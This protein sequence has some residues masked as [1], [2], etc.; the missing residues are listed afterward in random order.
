MVSA[1]NHAECRT[2]VLVISMESAQDRR[3]VFTRNAPPEGWWTFMNAYTNVH[4]GL[5]YSEQDIRQTHGRLLTAGELGCYS[6][7]YAAWTYL[8]E[9]SECDALIVLEDDVI[10]DW[11]FLQKLN[12]A[13]LPGIDYLRLYQKRPT[14]FRVLKKGYLERTKSL[15]QLYGFAFGTQGYYITKSGAAAMMAAAKTVRAPID[16]IMDR[17][18][19]HGVINHCIFPFPLIERSAPSNIGND[20]FANQHASSSTLGARLDKVRNKARYYR[21]LLK[22]FMGR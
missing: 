6:S 19:E 14:R 13:D 10:A 3:T 12:T 15:L 1:G 22:F 4:P 9:S 17:S 21:G 20:R 2:K 7:H 11:V 18:W 5:S 16:D 8:V